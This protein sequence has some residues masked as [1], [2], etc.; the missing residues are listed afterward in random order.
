MGDRA[1]AISDALR[2][3]SL[4]SEARVPLTT[5]EA[6]R[7]LGLHY[8]TALRWLEAAEGAG[9]VENVVREGSRPWRWA[10]SPRAR[11]IRVA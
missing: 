8:R 4:F 5:R 2:V 10:L 11:R 6:A 3:I 1:R 7:E 9:I